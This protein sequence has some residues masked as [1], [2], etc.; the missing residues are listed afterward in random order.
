MILSF[1]PCFTGD[2]FINCG[3]RRLTSED[4]A[5]L[6][7]ASVVILP[8]AC[9]RELYEAATTHCPRVFPDFDTKFAYPGKTG[10]IS[11]F[12]RT[13]TP[14]P[15]THLFSDTA[16][17]YAGTG[18]PGATMPFQFP[19]VLKLNGADEGYGVFLAK[20]ADELPP[21]LDLAA[22]AEKTGEAGFIIQEYIETGGR[23]LRVCVI[24]KT[25][26]AYWRVSQNPADFRVNLAR[27]AAIDEESF[28]ELRNKGAAAVKDFCEKT[29]INLAGFDL[30]F[31]SSDRTCQ[32]LFLEINYYFGR[33]GLGGTEKYYHLLTQEIEK[34]LT[35]QTKTGAHPCSAR[36]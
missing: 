23:V 22:R 34:W 3:G 35:D 27:G 25:I 24:Y 5:V 14:H 17:F 7:Q 15:K 21:L 32:P 13:G 29:G 16:D 12:R 9:K 4:I 8:Q 18:K 1:H 33:R 11:L 26:R 6:K 2:V 31:S 10:Q 28:P 20:T 30:V 19:A 36:V